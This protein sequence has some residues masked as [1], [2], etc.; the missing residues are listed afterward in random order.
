MRALELAHVSKRFKEIEALQDV[1]L[2][3]DF[4][5][6]FGYIGPNGAGKTTTIRIIL[7]LLRPCAGEVRVLG[8]DPR[9]EAGLV[10]GQ[11]GFLFEQP[12]IYDDLTV[13]ENLLLFARI[14]GVRA[15]LERVSQVIEHM[16]LS[17]VRNRH[18]RSL[19]KGMSQR[20]VVARLLLHKPRVFVL[21]EPTEGLDP[22]A[23]RE[24]LTVLRGL[25]NEGCAI[26]LSSHNLHQVEA[27]CDRVGL[28]YRGRLCCQGNMESLVNQARASKFRLVP[29][30]CPSVVEVERRM[31][32]MPGVLKV[33]LNHGAV[34]V[35]GQENIEASDICQWLKGQGIE[36]FDVQ[37]MDLTLSDVYD[38]KVPA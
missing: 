38:L 10:R 13:E 21:D 2:A 6:V 28:I 8:G 27:I 24:M 35:L 32:S 12:R 33:Y 34:E 20:V 37:R 29:S 18:G 16:N 26:F 15:P 7:G 3:V 22:Q 30:G 23:Q 5:E 14:Y 17:S 31:R 4:G 11:I 1:T 19:S 25:A 36:V 9:A